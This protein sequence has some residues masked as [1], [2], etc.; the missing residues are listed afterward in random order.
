MKK[1]KNYAKN[2]NLSVCVFLFVLYLILAVIL[3][4]AD[5]ILSLYL[6]TVMD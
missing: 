6:V 4:S 1:K 5:S 3:L 2:T